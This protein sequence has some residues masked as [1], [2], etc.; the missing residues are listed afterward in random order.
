M[1]RLGRLLAVSVAG[2]AIGSGVAAAPKHSQLLVQTQSCF[3]GKTEH[4]TGTFVAVFSP[5]Q[6]GPIDK[7]WSERERLSAVLN[8]TQSSDAA[9][10]YFKFSN[11]F[12]EKLEVQ[13]ALGRIKGMKGWWV[14][15][16]VPMAQ[17]LIV[18]GYR[19]DEGELEP[20]PLRVEIK[21]TANK[22]TPV[23]LDYTDPVL[24]RWRGTGNPYAK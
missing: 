17:R 18:Y 13:P 11:A 5:E 14:R 2:C 7:M 24:C 23:T 19:S 1:R 20:Q 3:E 10:K 15:L 22:E 8:K 12:F 4:P 9:D 6:A 16:G 21:P